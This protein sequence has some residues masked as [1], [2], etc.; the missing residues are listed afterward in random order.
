MYAPTKAGEKRTFWAWVRIAFIVAA[1]LLWWDEH[2]KVKQLTSQ[3]SSKPEQTVQVN[4]PPINIPAPI[5]NLPPQA[6]YVSSVDVG[7]VVPNYKIGGNWAVTE[8]CQNISPSGIADDAACVQ[9]VRV[10]DTKPNIF[11][12]P[13]VPEAVEE[14]LYQEFQKELATVKPQRR[15]LG[16]GESE[17]GTVF[18]PTIDA[19]S[20]EEF[21]SGSKTII[22]F[23]NNSWKDAVGWHENDV[24]QWL[25]LYPQMFTAP[26]ALATN[27]Q[28]VWHYCG[29][30]NGLR[31]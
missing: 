12:Q 1:V 20:D 8:K 14:R 7:V 30:H 10:A 26:G 31:K 18:S 13:I 29:K 6:A 17:L 21:R 16:P 2:S 11:K 28:I 5:V 4:V 23:S 25:Q 27:S 24:C 19:L 22:F 9:G 3:L 15:T